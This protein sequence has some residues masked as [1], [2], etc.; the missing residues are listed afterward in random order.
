VVPLADD[1]AEHALQRPPILLV[2]PSEPAQDEPLLDG[3]KQRLEDGGLE[4]P[5]LLPL[6]DGGFAEG[7]SQT[8]LSGPPVDRPSWS[9]LSG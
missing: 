2:E 4:E 6:G 3:R 9:T 1:L 7:L 8:G 5:G